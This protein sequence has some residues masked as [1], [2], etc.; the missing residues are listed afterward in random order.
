M[1]RH[2][3]TSQPIFSAV[4]AA[5][6]SQRVCTFLYKLCKLQNKLT[7]GVAKL[8]WLLHREPMLRYYYSLHSR[9]FPSVMTYVSESLICILP[10]PMP[11]LDMGDW[12]SKV[13]TIQGIRKAASLQN[14]KKEAMITTYDPYD[15]PCTKKAFASC[16]CNFQMPKLQFFRGIRPRPWWVMDAALGDQKSTVFRWSQWVVTICQWKIIDD[17]VSW[18]IFGPRNSILYIHKPWMD[19]HCMYW[20]SAN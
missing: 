12:S 19:F 8:L 10:Q 16:I 11:I 14:M 1:W 2:W 4:I 20:K 9:K 15:P 13:Q 17:L 18:T 6:G 3:N 7:A 5:K